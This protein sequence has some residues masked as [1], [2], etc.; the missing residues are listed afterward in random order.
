M[1][2]KEILIMTCEIWKSIT[3]LEHEKF[4]DKD[5]FANL[6]RTAHEQPDRVEINS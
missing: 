1:K 6:E 2:S 5:P 3:K 4:P